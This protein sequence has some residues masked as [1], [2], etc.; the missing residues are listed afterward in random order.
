MPFGE[1]NTTLDQ[2]AFMGDMRTEDEKLQEALNIALDVML[3]AK[4]DRKEAKAAQDDEGMG[5]DQVGQP[6]STDTTKLD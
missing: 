6:G 4:E 5:G 1:A 2:T 3:Q